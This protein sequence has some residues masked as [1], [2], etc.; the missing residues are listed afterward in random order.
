MLIPHDR[1]T[2]SLPNKKRFVDDSHGPLLLFSQ[3]GQ[4]RLLSRLLL[5]LHLDSRT[6]MA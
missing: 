4:L 5:Q 6:T 3:R 1:P 2:L